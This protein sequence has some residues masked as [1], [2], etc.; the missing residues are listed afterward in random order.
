MSNAESVVLVVAAL[1]FVVARWLDGMSKRRSDENMEILRGLQKPTWN[2]T[3]D[4][5]PKCGVMRPCGIH[6]VRGAVLGPPGGCVYFPADSKAVYTAPLGTP[7]PERGAVPPPPWE[8]VS[9]GYV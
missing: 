6:G 5:C 9:H 3:Y 4:T 2:G 8:E 7:M 1:L